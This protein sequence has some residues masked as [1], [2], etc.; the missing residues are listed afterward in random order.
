MREL[1]LSRD[2]R[3]L[4]IRGL[5]LHAQRLGKEFAAAATWGRLIRDRGWLRPRTRVHPATPKEGIRATRPNEY[6]HIDVTGIGLLDGT[7]VYL[8]AVIDTSAGA[9]LRGSSHC[10][11]S[12]RRPARSSPKPPRAPT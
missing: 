11:L 10:G 5:A 7:R 12:R 3:R 8:L 6:W 1:V 9:F 2:H 4:T